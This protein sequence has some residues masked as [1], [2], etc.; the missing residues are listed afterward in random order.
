MRLALSMLLLTGVMETA[1]AATDGQVQR[2]KTF[3]GAN[4]ATCHAVGR[5]GESPLAVAP[6]FR[7]LH[8]R[9][10]IEDLGE[11]LAEGITT[12]HPTMPQFQLEP[13]QITDVLAY[14]KSLER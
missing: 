2:G 8:T 10:P 3:V 13:D 12:G 7:D 1:A 9:Y 5:I 6:A 14:L 4:C 11:A